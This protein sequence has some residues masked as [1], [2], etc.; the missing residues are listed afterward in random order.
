[1]SEGKASWKFPRTFWTGNAA[2][3]F[4]RAAYYGMFITLFRYLNIDIGFTDPQAGWIT[5][6]FLAA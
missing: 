5:G 3:L 1:M 4:E 2:E 6:L